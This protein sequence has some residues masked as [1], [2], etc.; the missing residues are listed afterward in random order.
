[1][2]GDYRLPNENLARQEVSTRIHFQLLVPNHACG[3]ALAALAILPTPAARQ[4]GD[5]AWLEK[6]FLKWEDLQYAAGG[7]FQHWYIHRKFYNEA[8]Q[9]GGRF[10]P[11]EISGDDG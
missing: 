7:P 11:I 4:G 6:C 5:E 9:H 2:W 1:M 10:N 8:V 3:G